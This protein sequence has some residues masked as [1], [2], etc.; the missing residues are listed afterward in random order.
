MGSKASDPTD[1]ITCYDVWPRIEPI[2]ENILKKVN[3]NEEIRVPEKQQMAKGRM[4]A[5]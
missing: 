5:G 1:M 3:E 2:W 4:R